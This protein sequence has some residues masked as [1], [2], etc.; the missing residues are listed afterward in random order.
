[1]ADEVRANTD[2]LAWFVDNGQRYL[3]NL[4]EISE[5]L[6]SRRA[7]VAAELDFDTG[8]SAVRPFDELLAEVSVNNRFVDTIRVALNVHQFEGSAKTAPAGRIT[9]ALETA[10]LNLGGEDLSLAEDQLLANAAPVG[11]VGDDALILVAGWMRSQRI[12]FLSNDELLGL[13]LR[14]TYNGDDGRVDVPREVLQAVSY[15][16][17]N[18]ELAAEVSRMTGPQG[19]FT[20][21]FS[22]DDLRKTVAVNRGVRALADRETFRAVDSDGDGRI[23]FGEISQAQGAVAPEVFAALQALADLGPNPLRTLNTN[24]VPFIQLAGEAERRRV[25]DDDLNHTFEDRL[26]YTDIVGAAINRHAFANDPDAA[27]RFVTQLPTA[28]DDLSG[29]ESGFDIRL[30]NDRALRALANASLA[31]ADGLLEQTMVVAHLPESEGAVRNLLITAYYAEVGQRMNARLNSGLADPLDPSLAG[32]TG[33]NWLI[34]APNASNGVR[35]VITADLT[36]FGFA[37]SQGDR[38]AAADGNQ[39]IFGTLTVPAAAFLEAFPE[40]AS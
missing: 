16:H 3:A 23:S 35:P 12:S 30:V 39:Y 9:A 28:F 24:N 27:F 26:S 2:D 25:S 13:R 33:A 21:G 7:A 18:P 31:G 8:W 11:P 37:P 5:T 19:A 4:S 17:R 20:T 34:F 40:G 10:G 6:R 22:V 38:Q 36:A 32:H 15:L 29:K 1:M 14:G